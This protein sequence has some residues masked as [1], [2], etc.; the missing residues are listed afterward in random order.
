MLGSSDVLTVE[1]LDPKESPYITFTWQYRAAG[2][3]R[4][5]HYS[6]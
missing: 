1:Y 5:Y 2:R 6:I 4:D 3:C